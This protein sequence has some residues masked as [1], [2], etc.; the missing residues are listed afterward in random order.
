MIKKK[1]YKV[2]FIGTDNETILDRYMNILSS[3]KNLGFKDGH[4]IVSEES[5]SR[6]KDEIPDGCYSIQE[7]FEEL[8]NNDIGQFLKLS[9]F[10]YQKDIVKF[11]IQKKNGIIV[12]PC[13]SGR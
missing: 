6:I 10:P 1:S 9:L 3:D 2:R 5:A 8:P 13:G 7:V 4:F 11:C 12:L